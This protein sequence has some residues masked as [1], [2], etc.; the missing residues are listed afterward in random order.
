MAGGNRQLSLPHALGVVAG[1]LLGAGA[2]Y[3][4]ER[5][6]NLAGPATPL[7]FLVAA[8][9]A[10]AL[11]VGY[12]TF[13]SGPLGD[14]GAGAYLHLSRT[15]RSRAVG[16]FFTWPTV[17]AYA[18]LLAL[19]ARYLARLAPL[20][21]PENV[22]ALGTLGVLLALHLAGPVAVGRVGLVLSGV[23]TLF[24]LVLSVAALSV[25]VPGNFVPLFPTPV[26]REQPVLSVGRGAVVALFGFVGFEACAALAGSVRLPRETLPRA[27]VGGVAGVGVLVTLLAF[28]TLGVVPWARM[29]FA[30]VPFV[31]AAASGLSVPASALVAPGLVLATLAALVALS[32][33]PT[34]TLAGLGELV[35]PLAHAN[36]GGAPDV[37][38]VVVFA[39]AG[40]LVSV[41][42]VFVGLFLA[43]P[44][45]LVCYV[46]HGLTTAALP[47]V[48]PDLY[49]TCEFRLS[50]RLLAL[51]GLSGAGLAGL[52]LWQA[53]TLDPA[54]VLGYTRVGPAVTG[55]A[56]DPL[57]RSPME[58]AIPALVGWE[59]LGVLVYVAARDYREE[60]G[61]ELE[62]LTRY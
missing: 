18:A 16:F 15:W 1:A 19:L 60:V 5:V 8:A 3:I 10:L 33:A 7:S 38:S 12:A 56:A 48:N 11:A 24:V 53:L 47:V 49:R 17:A 34:R 21:L 51:C 44:G 23:F 41:D 55:P 42:A 52:L 31:D 32:W 50:P 28:V 4:P 46:A 61:V 59:T 43:V 57:V 22:V 29:I 37:A 20:G 26:L 35:P 45:L 62:P 40:A 14:D 6:E 13:C 58:S 39:L 30:S 25:V 2:L 27:L 54:I 36:R 9:G